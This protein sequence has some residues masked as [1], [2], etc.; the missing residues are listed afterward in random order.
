MSI[1]KEKLTKLC[2]IEGFAT[3][4]DL[5][6]AAITD[7]VCPAICMNSDCD[8]STELEPDQDQ[9]WCEVCETN[10]MKSALILM[11]FI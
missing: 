3:P 1:T 9:G 2:E 4:L 5:A 7:S 6:P 10:S 11:G 8:Y